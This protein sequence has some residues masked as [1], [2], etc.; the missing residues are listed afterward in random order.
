VQ[1]LLSRA[2]N[3]PITLGALIAMEFDALG[4]NTSGSKI[5]LFGGPEARLHKG[6]VE[7]F[8]LAIHE[9]LTN[10]VKYGAFASESGSLSVTWHIEGMPPNQRLVL[11]WIERGIAL[12]APASD[13]KRKGYGRSSS[14]RRCPIRSRPRRHSSSTP[15]AYAAGLAFPSRARTATRRSHDHEWAG[16]IL[17][18]HF[19]LTFPVTDASR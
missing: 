13:P 16:P 2:E 10:A 19:K 18:D 6:A 3:E 5:S 15:M 1:G 17:S 11:E 12:P 9:L 7:M 14:R 4:L 8:A